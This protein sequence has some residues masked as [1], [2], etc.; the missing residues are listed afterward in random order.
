MAMDEDILGLAMAGVI[1]DAS[2][3]PP[4]PDQLA[5]IQD[6]WKKMAG[7]I[8]AHIQDFAEV[9]QGIPVTTTGSPTAQAG[10][11]IAPGKVL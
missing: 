5:N 1:V 4:T 6:F 11:T 3:V 2:S 7:V 10:T 8:I 9:P